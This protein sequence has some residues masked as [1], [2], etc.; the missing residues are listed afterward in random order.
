MPVTVLWLLSA[1]MGRSGPLRCTLIQARVGSRA[2][3]Y[4]EALQRIRTPIAAHVRFIFASKAL[5]RGCERRSV[6]RNE[7]LMPYTLPA[8]S[9]YARSSRSIAFS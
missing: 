4:L 7:P 2:I 8:R 3:P 1:M 9:W 6:N 5:N